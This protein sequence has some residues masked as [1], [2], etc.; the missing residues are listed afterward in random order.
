MKA[1][2]TMGHL[3]GLDHEFKV[4]PEDNIVRVSPATCSYGVQG[5]T[6]EELDVNRVGEHN[7]IRGTRKLMVYAGN[8]YDDHIHIYEVGE[9]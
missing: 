8:G 1:G 9:L 3:E 2:I 7:K 4:M 6:D 5:Q